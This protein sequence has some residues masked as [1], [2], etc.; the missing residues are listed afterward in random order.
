MPIIAQSVLRLVCVAAFCLAATTLWVVD[1]AH[2][3]IMESTAAS[4]E[5]VAG[6]LQ[7]LYW[8]ELLWRGSLHKTLV[9]PVP[10]WETLETLKLISPGVCVDFAPGDG[11]AKRLCSQIEG[12]GAAAPAW[13]S[14]VFL[15]WFGA[16]PPISRFMTVRQKDAGVLT[17]QANSQA[18]VRLA[19]REASI[20]LRV[21]TLMVIAVVLLGALALGHLLAPTRA[22]VSSLRRLERGDFGV[23]LPAFGAAEFGVIARAVD[24]LASRLSEV[25]EERIALTRRLFEVQEEERRALARDLHDEFG[26][27]LA[28]ATAFAASIEAGAKDRPDLAED[29]RAISRL[30]RS[31]RATLRQA[32]ARLRAQELEELGLEASLARLVAGWN[33]QAGRGPAFRLDV[34]GDLAGLPGTVTIGVYRVAQECLT[35]AARHGRPNEVRLS[36]AR[37]AAAGGGVA[38]C[39]EDDGGGH[40]GRILA[41]P[42]SGV[43]GMRER[44]SALGGNLRIAEA[45]R[46]VRVEAY[47]PVREAA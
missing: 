13:F 11:P 3:A 34:S 10:E 16:P 44:I 23:S 45:P 9:L 37:V 8:R 27:N 1:S 46:G 2:E 39:V 26:Q 7:N 15:A 12:V 36:I 19:W 21:A 41:A 14:R 29:A 32:L 22:I 31:M 28:A 38:L 24:D 25:T 5:R 42:G 47:I 30:A 33:A 4:A 6:Q 43:L 20:V 17:V 18:A 40:A 35:N